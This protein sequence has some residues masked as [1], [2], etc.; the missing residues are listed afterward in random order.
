MRNALCTA[1]A[2]CMIAGACPAHAD[3]LADQFRDPPQ[4]ARPRVWWHW[5]NG[6]ITKDGIAKDLAWMQD[7]GIGGVHVFDVNL[8][9]P[10]IVDKRLVYMTPD[11][12]DAFHFAVTEA[13][14]R[15][16]EL[17][18][19]SS[20]GW[21][22][23]G[24]PWV[25]PRDGLKKLVWSETRLLP[26]QRATQPL[27]LPPGVTGPYQSLTM[28]PG[29]DDAASGQK[30]PTPPQLYC[31]IAVLAV[32]VREAALPAPTARSGA[33]VALDAAILTGADLEHPVLVA[34][35]AAG[36]PASV[37][38]SWPQPQ[39][40][41]AVHVFIAHASVMF[42]GT[43]VSPVLEASDDGRTWRKVAD[44]PAEG[45]P[46]TIGFAP[47]T[48]RQFR[49]VL[50]PN[51]PVMSNM[52][53]P[54]PGIIMPGLFG[55][56]P[57]GVQ[58]PWDVRQFRLDASPAVDRFETKAGFALSMDYFKLANPA[59]GATGARPADVIDLTVQLG[60]DDRLDWTAPTLPAGWSWRVIRLG[61]S[62]LGTTNHPAPAEATG[63]EVDKFDAPA[64]NRYITHYL[65]MIRDA[66]GPGLVG[67]RGVTAL[68]NDSIE[69][70]AAN[71][72]PAMLAAFQSARGYDARPWLPALTGVL[73]GSRSETDAF[74][75]DWRRTLA[76]LMASAHYGTIA[77]AAHAN[78]LK[79]YGEALEDKRPS[80][81]DDMA[82]RSH[83]DI[84]MAALWT[85]PQGSPPN[86]SYIADMRGAASVAHIYGQNLVAAESM[87]S[88]LNYWADSPRTL[89]H[90]IDTE[91]LN[92]VNRPVVH[93]SVH[94]PT[95]D[96]QP[97]LSLLIFGQFFNRH[98]AWAPL[99]RAWVDYMARNALMLQQG[100]FIA[101]LGYFYGEEAPLTGL[102]GLAPV[103]DAPVTHGYDFVNADAL[104]HVLG[105]RGDTLISP[106]GA[107]YRALYLGGSSRHM[108][109]IA[110]TRIAA[111]VE[112]GARVIGHPP[113][114]DPGMAG[115]DSAKYAALVAR[116]WPQGDV[117]GADAK[118]GAGRVVVAADAESGLAALG[119]ASDFVGTADTG[120]VHRHWAQ[121]DDWFVVNRGQ[122]ATTTEAHFRV[123]GKVPELWQAETG[124][125]EPVSYR[126]VGGETIV[127][128]AL[129]GEGAVHVVFRK[130]GAA[131]AMVGVP[132]PHTAAGLDGAWTVAFQPG[133]GAPA[134]TVLAPLTPLNANA[135]SG[136]SHFAGVATYHHDL[137]TPAA[138]QP[139]QPLWLNLGDV[140]EMAEVRVN[141]QVAGTL[142]HP[143][144]RIDIGG[145]VH[146]GAN[147]LDLRVATLWVNRLIGDAKPGAVKV[148]WTALPTYRADAPLRPAGLIGPVTLEVAGK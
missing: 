16:M 138:W 48:A 117:L 4:P 38:L 10:Q 123:T 55:G 148:A 75:F 94:Q 98:E 122:G 29:I 49:L 41:R 132:V 14:R 58:P 54:A 36:D 129:D 101:D 3:D 68:L 83:T 80:L 126:I 22:E 28:Q 127:P 85:Y 91:F 21:S 145:L 37:V 77:R 144:Y 26:G 102:Y 72:T 63:L 18:V 7:V 23:T 134:T 143:P 110:L 147:T 9:T 114:G 32:P 57:N 44:V 109:L 43:L 93:D 97:G 99:A 6:N 111:L 2:A 45:V 103:A 74:L 34:H 46:T 130:A 121:G 33:G 13:D 70:G 12:K 40:V 62:L 65:G 118:V 59:D 133:R 137:I 131:S 95:D 135:D 106:G 17:A 76:D 88:A 115:A 124:H 79:L 30:P 42:A 73:I 35:P 104:L 53:A 120:F 96:K 141:G 112:G 142:W 8:M 107:Q 11:W 51:A 82:M 61:H 113:I 105:N 19:A 140:R 139:G 78:G 100:H 86:P 71:W 119:V 67:A 1:L 20:P 89:K 47:V 27:A 81:G 108:S 64:V 146:R 56:P 5:M 69:V 87:T 39:T 136:I 25:T 84:P 50:H 31:D 66:A 125:S 116:L 128:L 24:G 90:V 52:G 60:A 15:G 92:G